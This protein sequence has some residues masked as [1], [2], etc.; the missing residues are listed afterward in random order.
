MQQASALAARA[1]HVKYKV[2]Y[3]FGASLDGAHP[4]ASL[5]DV[6]GVLYGTTSGGGSYSQCDVDGFYGC[7]TVFSLTTN[8]VENVV[9]SFGKGTDGRHPDAGLLGVN[10]KVYGTTS[11]GGEYKDGTV[12]ALTP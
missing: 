5:I 6:G 3:S 7:G 10:G 12:F 1:D 2:V 4:Q 8:G 11:G 9:H